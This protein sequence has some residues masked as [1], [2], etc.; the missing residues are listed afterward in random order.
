MAENTKAAWGAKDPSA[1]W[2]RET[3]DYHG[4]AERWVNGRLMRGAVSR[5]DDSDG[6]NGHGRLIFGSIN[7]APTSR[8][9]VSVSRFY[10]K[11]RIMYLH[12]LVWIWHN[13][14]I[15]GDLRVDHE[16]GDFGD[17]RIENFRL[18]TNAEN[19]MNRFRS[20]K[21]SLVPYIGVAVPSSGGFSAFT[22]EGS[23]PIYLGGFDDPIKAAL[24]RDAEVERRW[25]GIARLNRDLFPEV[26]QRYL[27]AR[28]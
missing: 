18:L 24:V 26:M 23:K 7:K 12:R 11:R 9:A 5:R 1:D 28:P 14:E 2:I 6:R 20:R 4:A 3:F 10:G 13:G 27:E 22:A 15:P 16:S 17:N 19:Q 25:P 8:A 21:G